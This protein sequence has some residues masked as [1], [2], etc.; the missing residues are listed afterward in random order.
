MPSKATKMSDEI[1]CQKISMSTR[2]GFFS[3][4]KYMYD[5]HTAFFYNDKH[6]ILA[7]THTINTKKKT[8]LL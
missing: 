4:Q 6:N 8:L 7:H 5:F 3:A 1:H 2:S